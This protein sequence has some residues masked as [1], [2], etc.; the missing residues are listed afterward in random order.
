[1]D[2][3]PSLSTATAPQFLHLAD[4][5]RML[6]AVGRRPPTRQT[7]IARGRRFAAANE[8]RIFTVGRDQFVSR[9]AVEQLLAEAVA[10]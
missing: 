2:G 8:L 5:G 6:L 9:V 4:L 1:M 10:S 3:A 7:L